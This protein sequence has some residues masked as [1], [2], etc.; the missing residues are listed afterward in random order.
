MLAVAVATLSLYSQPYC[1]LLKAMVVW[2]CCK[3]IAS[4]SKWHAM[5]FWVETGTQ[6]QVAKSVAPTAA[7]NLPYGHSAAAEER[8][9]ERHKER[10]TLF[11]SML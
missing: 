5:A 3:K 9:I 1:D 8:R 6:A 4:F 2:K 11:Q 7:E 10:K